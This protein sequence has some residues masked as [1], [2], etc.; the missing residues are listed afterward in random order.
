VYQTVVA[1]DLKNQVYQFAVGG[2]V[3][4]DPYARMAVPG[5][6]EGVVVDLAGV[7]PTGGWVATPPLANR[8][9]AVIYELNVR[10]FTIDPSSGVSPAMRGKYRG[11]VQTGGTSN[12]VRTGIDHLK[13]L[14]VTTVQLMPIQDFATTVPNW[15]YDPLYYNVPEEQYS[16][17]TAPEDRIREFKDMVNGFHRNGIRVVLDVVFNHTASKDV[18]QGITGQ[19]YTATDLAGCCGNSLDDSRPMVSRMIRDSLEMWVRDYNVDGFRFD[20][21][22]IFHHDQVASWGTYLNATYPG[23]TLQLYGE[24]WIGGANPADE[25]SFARYGTTPAMSAGRIG[26]FNGAYRDV[27]KGG[28]KD[29]V[30][31]YMGG[32]ANASA[33]ATGTR[34]S[35]LATKSNAVLSNL[36][37]SAFAY[38]PEQTINYVSV[39][40]DL[41]LWDKITYAGVAGG[42]TGRAGQMDRFAAGIVLTSQGVPL[43]AEGDE[44]LRSKVVNADYATAMNSYNAPDAVNA[45]HWGDKVTNAGVFAYYRAAIALRKATP[46]LRLTSWDE[47]VAKQ[48]VGITGSVVTSVINATVVVVNNPGSTAVTAALPAGSWTKVLDATGAVSTTNTS[49]D[50]LAVTVF[51]KGRP[52]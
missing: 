32:A 25:S 45:V 48:T 23:R 18:L 31:G 29:R 12:G 39:H 34:G 30:L 37:D 26:V 43:I 52:K 22:G 27:V 36:W 3:V 49:A 2:R 51:V 24:P 15:G 33:V 47:I 10:E 42:A 14:G 38:D 21:M 7:A 41:N 20:L 40:D 6:T 13:E 5:S 16:Q 4:P 17:A 28:T 19:Y 44:F 8:E 46:A 35:P 1:G 50:P 11:L 9:D